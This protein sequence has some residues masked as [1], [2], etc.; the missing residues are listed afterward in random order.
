MMK[1]W[2]GEGADRWNLSNSSGF[3]EVACQPKVFIELME[4]R[5]GLGSISVSK[6]RRIAAYQD[7]QYPLSQPSLGRHVRR[8]NSLRMHCL[9]VDSDH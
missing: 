4:Q 8:W 9:G 1:I 2:L 3:N 6:G 5:L 7:A